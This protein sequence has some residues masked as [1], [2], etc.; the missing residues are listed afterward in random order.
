MNLNNLISFDLKSDFNGFEFFQDQRSSSKQ[1]RKFFSTEEDLKLVSLVNQYGKTNKWNEIAQML[2]NGFNSRQC[3]E[4][5][6]NYLNPELNNG[7]YSQEEDDL[8][9]SLVGKYGNKW[10]IIHSSFVG[11]SEVSVKNRW[12]HLKRKMNKLN[13]VKESELKQIVHEEKQ[14]ED[15]G[16]MFDFNNYLTESN[17]IFDFDDFF[18]F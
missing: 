7:P 13:K 6:Q 5:Y 18:S 16:S 9:I 3:R 8:L 14:E 2:G 17:D 11:R 15:I 4:R 12:T 10:S 1:K